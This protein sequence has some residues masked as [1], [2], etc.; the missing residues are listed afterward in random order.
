MNTN[1]I[2]IRKNIF[3]AFSLLFIQVSTLFGQPV[4]GARTFCNPLNLNYRFMVDAVDAR[5]AADP[6]IVLYKDDYYLFASRSGGYWTSP[7]LR[8]WTLII[9]Q[10]LDIESYAPAAVVMRDTL[11]FMTP[12]SQIYKTTDPK[13][14]VW[15]KGPSLKS[16]GDPALL[17]DDDGRLYLSWGVSNTAPI[18]VV[19]LDPLTFKEIGSKVDVLTAHANIYGWERRGDDNLLDEQ[20]WIEGSWMIKANG[21]YYLHYAGPGTEFKT[22]GDG[23][24][25]A[26]APLGPYQ[27]ATYSPF[28]FKPTGFIT[29]VGHGAT[30]KD[31][32]GKYWHIGT[33]TISV[34]HMFER[35]LGL[36]PV[37]FDADGNIRCNTSWGD[38]PQLFP[39]TNS[40]PVDSSFAGIMLLSGKK[41]VVAS[42]SLETHEAKNA[43]DEDVRTYWSAQSGKPGEWI[44]LDLGKTCTLEAVQVNFAEHNTDPLLVRGRSNPLY[45]QYVLEYSADGINWTMLVDKSENNTDVPHDYIELEESVEARYVKLTN[46]FTPGNG[47]FAIRDLRIF[48]NSNQAVFTEVNDFTVERDAE[49]G[50]DALIY[51]T[52]VA[53]ADGYLINY[54]IAPDKLYNN[55][56]VYDTDSLAMHCLNHGVDYYFSVTAFDN[57]TDYYR[58]VGEFRSFQSGD[59][60]DVNSW[61]RYDGTEWVHPVSSLPEITIGPIT[62]Q[63]GDTIIVSASDSADQ[64]TIAQGG[65]LLVEK[66]ATFTVKNGIETDLVVEGLLIN[67]GMIP[68][69]EAVSISFSH[70]GR[71]E[72]K[73]DGGAIPFASWRNNSTIVFDSIK[74]TL[75]AGTNQDFYNLVWNCAD[76]ASDFSLLWNGNT[77]GGTITVE[78]TGSGILQLCDPAPGTTAL[79]NIE[80]DILLTGGQLTS[81]A[82]NSP[83]TSYT[84]NSY[85]NIEATAGTFSVCMGTQGGSG[86]TNWNHYGNV[87]MSGNT[88]MNLNPEGAIFTLARDTVVHLA[89]S[90]VTFG[91]GGFPIAVNNGVVLDM[92]TYSIG[93]DGSFSMKAGSRLITAH[94]EGINGSVASTGLKF[95][96]K[97]TSYEFNGTTAQVTG[98]YAPDSLLD[99][100]IN[101]PSGVSLSKPVFVNGTLTLL[102]GSLLPNGNTLSFG[103]GGSL[104]YAGTVAQTTTD[105]EF[106]LTK[107]PANLIVANTK[108]ITLHASRSITDLNLGY[109]LSLGVNTL[110]VDTISGKGAFAYLLTGDGGSLAYNSV[111]TSLAFYPVGTSSYAP[112]WIRN[113]GSPDKIS[114]GAVNDADESSY[115]GRVKLKWNISEENQGKGYYTLRFGWSSALENNA[116]KTD[117]TAN[118]KIFNLS[119]TLEAGTGAYTSQ[120]SKQPYTVERGGI[121]Q[122]GPFVVG[123]YT[124]PTEIIIPGSERPN[125]FSLSQNYPNPFRTTTEISF[126]L[127]VKSFVSLKVYNILGKEITEL[128]G[129]EYAA[130][131]HTVIL[132]GSGLAKG[133]YFYTISANG[134]VQSRKMMLVK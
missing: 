111:D 70:N 8:S 121:Y 23:I 69:D 127:P 64:L 74:T 107:G 31:K 1:A 91:T 125:G 133:I 15:Q 117:R 128:A 114:V 4:D 90:D 108:G 42:S 73:R 55:F 99:L 19:E 27:Y 112:V 37:D 18:S 76:Q 84:V 109:K 49:D 57:G 62:I 119:D 65:T 26:D 79:V 105:A 3:L 16:Y 9:P 33:M 39:G 116:F 80:G 98:N 122:L 34:K 41:Y 134:F 5:E 40:D 100:T 50:R 132:N 113:S 88:V 104:K 97:A 13:S 22:Y 21:K 63:N 85:G 29:G 43:C 12:G 83:G 94:P 2:N 126:G 81:S 38:Y 25:V 92:G 110:T 56:M 93:G 58:S 60:N 82:S 101:N 28:A 30:F 44:M 72:H 86:T 131:N 129:R 123:N 61:S 7:D 106:P 120:F 124:G 32:N 51:W 35:R 103:S 24:Y 130:G 71:Y 6:V 52:P 68:S 118:A 45:E 48:G 54:G 36:Y 17:L 10:G 53:G 102:N 78:H 87:S 77:I 66:D 47:N 115:N 14:G 20:P 59:W 67:S 46:V 89:L 11:F 75:P 96:D 95:F